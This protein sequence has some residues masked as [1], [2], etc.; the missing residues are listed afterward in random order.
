FARY[1]LRVVSLMAWISTPV[2][3]FLFVAAGPVI[4]MA[5]GHQWG[6]AAPVFQILVISALG[7][8]LFESTIWLFIGRGQSARLFKLLLVMSP[9]MIG[10]FAIGLPFGIKGVALSGSLVL[11]GILP[12]VLK[13]AFRGTALT[14]ERLG[15]ALL[16]PVLTCLGGIAAGEL[17]LHLVA[18]QTIFSQLAVSGLGFGLAYALAALSP[19]IRQ[20]VM[21]FRQ[22][23]GEFRLRRSPLQT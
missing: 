15:Q 14:L 8:L 23:L 17:A 9:I 10:S 21:S 13:F 4:A 20:E 19:P 1:Y 7:Q 2:F 6:E 3:G 11:V 5:L 18:P 12:W 22:L 16:Y